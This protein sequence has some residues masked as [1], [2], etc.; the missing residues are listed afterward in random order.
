[1]SGVTVQ[2]WSHRLRIC[3]AL[4]RL[5]I[6]SLSLVYTMCHC[7]AKTNKNHSRFDSGMAAARSIN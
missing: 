4:R 3:Q 7:R 5:K 2:E 6:M 1:M